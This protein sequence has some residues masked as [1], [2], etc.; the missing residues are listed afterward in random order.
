MSDLDPE[1]APPQVMRVE[2]LYLDEMG[3]GPEGLLTRRE[4]RDEC[5]R[6][7]RLG[8]DVFGPWCANLVTH[9]GLVKDFGVRVLFDG[10]GVREEAI[11]LP[12]YTPDFAATTVEDEINWDG[13]TLP[14]DL[15]FVGAT[16]LRRPVFTAVVF[17][18]KVFFTHARFVQGADFTSSQF[19][20]NAA[21]L[22][23]VFSDRAVFAHTRFG[24]SGNFNR[25]VFNSAADFDNATMFSGS[26]DGARFESEC[27]FR[28]TNFNERASFDSTRFTTDARFERAHFQCIATFHLAGFDGDAV[29]NNARFSEGAL[30][31]AIRARRRF[32]LMLSSLPT[33]PSLMLCSKG[34]LSFTE[35]SFGAEAT[36][37]ARRSLGPAYLRTLSFRTS[38]TFSASSLRLSPLR[39]WEWSRRR[40]SF[41]ETPVFRPPRRPPERSSTSSHSSS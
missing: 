33:R 2:P 19:Q 7:L 1:T 18:K 9:V 32:S 26:F 16:F 28:A 37:K 8:R 24:L 30:F 21:F 5:L 14:V 12:G 6:Q 13:R 4:W 15:V 27:S 17:P 3:Y 20:Q 22:E 23:T 39:F 10:G 36:L 29:F 11:E 34:M 41:F 35:S 25:A 38:D 40:R 31:D